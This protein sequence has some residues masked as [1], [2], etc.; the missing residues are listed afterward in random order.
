MLKLLGLFVG[1]AAVAGARTGPPPTSSGALF[2]SS[3]A[4]AGA[5]PVYATRDVFSALGP[6][7]P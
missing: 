6:S 7:R 3:I 5:P 1:L 2:P 4:I